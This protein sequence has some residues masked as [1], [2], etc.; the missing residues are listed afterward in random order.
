MSTGLVTRA[1]AFAARAHEGQLRKWTGE[2][3]ASH[4]DEVAELV[5]AAGAPEQVVAAAYLHDTVEDT[6]TTLD[7]LRAAFGEDVAD[8]VA[9]LTDVPLSAGNRATR[10]ALDRL[11]LAS[12]PPW[13]QTIKLADLISNTSTIAQHNPK[14]ARVYLA[15]KRAL[16]ALMTEG[17]LRLRLMALGMTAP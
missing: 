3:Y 1:R 5:A 16:L 7:D 12:A 8:M 2:P 15:E 17:D 10:K 14:F 6:P 13:V 11:R 9:L 4:V